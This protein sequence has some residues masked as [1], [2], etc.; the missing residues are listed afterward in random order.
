MTVDPGYNLDSFREE[1]RSLALR[2]KDL[3]DRSRICP[4]GHQILD[5]L[6]TH[7]RGRKRPDNGHKN[8]AWK[9]VRRLGRYSGMARH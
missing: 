3:S 5:H 6:Q 7:S 1:I 2:M 4:K 9:P 8:S